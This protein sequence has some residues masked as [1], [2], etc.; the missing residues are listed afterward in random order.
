MSASAASGTSPAGAATPSRLRVW[1]PVL[2]LCSVQAV[3]LLRTAWDKSDTIDEPHYLANAFQQ[4]QH[5]DLTGNCESPAFPKWGFAAALR[6]ADPRLFDPQVRQGHHPLWSRPQPQTR[7]NLFAARC[8]TVVLTVLAGLLLFLAASR[9]GRHAALAT[10]ALWCFSP[11]VLAAGSLAT[12]DAWAAGLMAAAVWAGVRFVERPRAAWA[13][14]LGALL[15]LAAA[16]KVTTLGLAPVLAVLLVWAARRG[17]Q[18]GPWLPRA[19]ALGAWTSLAFLLTLWTV[20]GFSV[21]TLDTGVLCGREVEGFTRRVL[22]PLPFTPWIEGLLAQWLHGRKGH[23]NYLFGEVSF[24]GWWWFFLAAIALKTT[25]GAQGLALLRVAVR[26]PVRRRDLRIDAALL[27]FPMLLL[28]VLSTGRT[29]NGIKYLLPAFPFVMLCV[30]RTVEDVRRA[31]GRRGQALCGALLL[32]GTLESVAVHPHHLMFFNLWAGGPE[33][34]PRYLIHGDD[35]GQDQRRL[36]EWQKQNRPWRLFYTHYSGNPRHWGISFEQP[37]CEPR[38]GYYALHAVE[39]H[40]PKRLPA[41][42]LDWLTVDEPDARLGY[43][44]YLYLA[45]KPRLAQ[46]QARRGR[47]EPFWSSAQ[48]EVR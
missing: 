18:G 36:A 47:V 28:V 40:R 12:L 15:A 16:S 23:H 4:W 1:L 5:G 19:G 24:D 14:V 38:P 3:L 10:L 43:S 45:N 42:C 17:A 29:Q 9:F 37:P 39:V 31:W 11:T 33:G 30:G 13:A 32:A 22:G 41:G 7:R 25:L 44:I 21:R 26:P 20:Y 46:L 34:G 6:L 2:L 27:A 48:E 35:W 8:V